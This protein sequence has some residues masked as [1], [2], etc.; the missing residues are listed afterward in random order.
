LTALPPPRTP[1]DVYTVALVCL[2]NICRSAM[3]Q[4]VLERKLD[5]AGISQRVAVNS[6]GTGDWH[7]G[8]QM[9]RRAASTLTAAG[10]D[11]TR[12]RSRLF[13]ADWYDNHD[14][15]LVM[16]EMNRADVLKLAQRPED[17][18]RVMMFRAFDPEAGDDLVLA[19]PWYG[20]QSGFEDVLATV[21][22][23]TDALVELLAAR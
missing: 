4:V 5:E 2:G 21:E 13:E 10:Y 18:G 8:E 3:A 22:R 14:L 7:I 17:H 9:D 15:I 1:G 6:S 20:G 23:T 11:A 16:D 12:H 19:D